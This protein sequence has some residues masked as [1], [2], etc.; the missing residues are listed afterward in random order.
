MTRL[1]LIVSPRVG[2]IEDSRLVAS[3]LETLQGTAP[4]ARMMGEVWRSAQ[5]LRVVRQEPFATGAAKIQTLHIARRGGA[6]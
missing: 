1:S 4:G 6:R 2:P 5:T 3:V